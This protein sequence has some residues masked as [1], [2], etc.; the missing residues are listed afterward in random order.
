MALSSPSL[1]EMGNACSIHAQQFTPKG[2]HSTNLIING[3]REGRGK[4]RKGRKVIPPS[5]SVG[6]SRSL[7]FS[8]SFPLSVVVWEKCISV[9]HITHSMSFV[10]VRDCSAEKFRGSILILATD[11]NSEVILGK[12][13]CRGNLRL[14]SVRLNE[15][16]GWLAD[17]CLRSLSCGAIICHHRKSRR[18]GGGGSPLL[19]HHE[20]AS[21][22]SCELGDGLLISSRIG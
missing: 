16:S 5:Q 15:T 17:G 3:R 9:S 8:S 18:G 6:R 21:I 22:A 19:L 2:E 1:L 7:L 12:K 20:Q 10:H 11:L 14:C 4:Q 13:S